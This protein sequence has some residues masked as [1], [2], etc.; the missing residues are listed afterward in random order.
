M[1]VFYFNLPD[2]D[3]AALRQRSLETSVPV[4][5]LLRDGVRAVLS[6]NLGCCLLF[7]GGAYVSGVI[8]NVR[9]NG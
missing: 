7:S 1:G 6:G 9:V 5:A 2:N 8:V 3:L 4:A